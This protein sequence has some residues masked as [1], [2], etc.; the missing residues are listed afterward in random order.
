MHGVHDSA[1]DG[2]PNEG[3]R[4]GICTTCGCCHRWEALLRPPPLPCDLL[5]VLKRVGVQHDPCVGPPFGAARHEAHL[6]DG[7]VAIAHHNSGCSARCRHFCSRSERAS[8]RMRK[9]AHLTFSRWCMAQW[10]GTCV[11]RDKRRHE[12]REVRGQSGSGEHTCTR[13]FPP[14][15]GYSG[16]TSGWNGCMGGYVVLPRGRYPAGCRWSR[17]YNAA[18]VQEFVMVRMVRHVRGWGCSLHPPRGPENA[19]ATPLVGLVR[20]LSA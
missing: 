6:I 13:P 4:H 18:G 16:E 1:K 7:N 20:S 5:Q 19:H 2:R 9:W 15:A 10:I 14:H 12:I 3:Q 11:P 8:D 17:A